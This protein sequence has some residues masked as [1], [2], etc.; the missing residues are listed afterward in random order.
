MHFEW[1][2]EK[3]ASNLRK[4]GVS[5]EEAVT[6]FFDPLSATFSDPDHS[7]DERRFVTIG[8]S[9]RQRLTVV[10]HTERKGSSARARPQNVRRNDMKVNGHTKNDEM[11]PEYEFDYSSA[12]R[13]KYHRRL[14]KEGANVA[15]L[16]PDV[17]KQFP[18][19]AAVNDALRSLLEVSKITKRLRDRSIRRQR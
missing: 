10:C 16:E 19:S 15:V 5:F 14:L 13:G 4:H 11:R 2:H 9:S 7:V 18:S 6:L 8:Y 12:V 1:D 3:A 17:A